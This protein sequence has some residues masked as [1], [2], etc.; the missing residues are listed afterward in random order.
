[1]A[2]DGLLW[3][4]TW[5]Y[6]I[7]NSWGLAIVGVTIL[8]RIIMHPLTQKQMHSMRKMQELQPRMKVIQEKYAD[9]KD[10]QSK[11]IMELYKENKVN[12]ASGCL[13]L[14]VQLPIFILLFTVLTRHGFEGATFLSIRLYGSCLSTVADAIRLVDPVTGVR[15]AEEELGVLVVVFSALS[16]PLLLFANVGL[17]L[18]NT[19]LLLVVG[20][21]TWYQQRIA[22]VGNPQMAMMNWLMPIFMTFICLGF[23]GG[24]VLYWGVSSLLGVVAQMFVMRKTTEEMQ[25]KPVLLKEKPTQKEAE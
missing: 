10:M 21:L 4:L 23:P 17:W 3:L 20:F 6:D 18:P 7:T 8:T 5:F 11:K 15:L 9:D 1:M 13:P 19:I 12:P 2:G 14:L 16:N 22:S 24:V 25:K